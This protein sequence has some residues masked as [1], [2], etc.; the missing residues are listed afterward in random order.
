MKGKVRKLIR[1]RGFG[2]ILSED[3]QEVFFHLSEL[4]EVKFESLGEDDGVE[5]DIE[6]TRK[7]SQAR[8]VRVITPK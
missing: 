1:D 5:F 7:G 3:G 4:Q 6:A 8:N 2:F